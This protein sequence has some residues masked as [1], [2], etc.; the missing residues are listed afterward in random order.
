M[1]FAS[2]FGFFTSLLSRQEFNVAV[3]MCDK[4]LSWFGWDTSRVLGCFSTLVAATS[5]IV[6][7]LIGMVVLIN[8]DTR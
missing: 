4:L 8:L 3:G 7:L 6:G 5:T 2:F 1:D